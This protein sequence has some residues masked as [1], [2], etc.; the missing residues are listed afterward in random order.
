MTPTHLLSL[1]R[2]REAPTENSRRATVRGGKKNAVLVGFFLLLLAFPAS[3]LSF[4]SAT[5]SYSIT[6]NTSY[7]GVNNGISVS[8][9]MDGASTGFN[10]PHTFSGLS[11]THNFTMAYEDASG[12]PFSG[13][14]IT[15]PGD[16]DLST[17]TVSSEGT[18]WAF[19]DTHV[20]RS[21]GGDID[22]VSSAE[23]RNYVTPSDPTVV[24]AA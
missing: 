8:I 4:V 19:Y 21:N 14:D 17:L 2:N 11:G 24:A 23:H 10:T 5:A 15:A 9:L 18:Y 7:N 6:I 20:P 3:S 16:H 12:H 22:S 13:W 1:R